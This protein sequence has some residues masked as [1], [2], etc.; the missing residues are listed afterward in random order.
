MI[1][2]AHDFITFLAHRE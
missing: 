1:N 2:V